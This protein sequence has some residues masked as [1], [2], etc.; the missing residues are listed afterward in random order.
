L[1]AIVPYCKAKE[2]AQNCKNAITKKIDNF[3]ETM[4]NQ[5]T[6]IVKEQLYRIL[7]FIM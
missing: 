2:L 4:P 1:L 5:Y 3:V 6:A 7:T